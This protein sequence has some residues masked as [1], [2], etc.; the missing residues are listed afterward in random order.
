MKLCIYRNKVFYAGVFL[1]LAASLVFSSSANP[2][3]YIKTIENNEGLDAVA[4]INENAVL[5]AENVSWVRGFL[6]PPTPPNLERWNLNCCSGPASPCK[7]Y[8]GNIGVLTLIMALHQSNAYIEAHGEVFE[9]FDG[10]Y[11][12]VVEAWDIFEVPYDNCGDINIDCSVNIADLTYLVDYLFSGGNEPLPYL[13]CADINGDDAVNIADLT[14]LV[15]FMFSGGDAPVD[16]CCD[17][18]W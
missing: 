4:S 3:S 15:E 12:V 13:C 16:D 1:V 2:I 7:I 8:P 5:N 10:R 18:I 9:D 11:I 17:P 6:K 14:R